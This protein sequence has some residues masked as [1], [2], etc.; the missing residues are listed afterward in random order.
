MG[1]ILVALA[2]TLLLIAGVFLLIPN[3]VHADTDYGGRDIFF[4][5][6]TAVTPTA[7]PYEEPGIAKCDEVNRQHRTAAAGAALAGLV[8]GAPGA[9]L[10]ARQRRRP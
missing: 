1:W 5:C 7:E 8:L 6:G 4:G 2:A 10:V 9:Y 3:S